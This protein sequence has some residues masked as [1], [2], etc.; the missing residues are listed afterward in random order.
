MSAD[1]PTID[2]LSRR[3]LKAMDQ[4]GNCRD[5]KHAMATH[6]TNR[7]QNQKT[8]ENL[9]SLLQRRQQ[10]VDTNDVEHARSRATVSNQMPDEEAQTQHRQE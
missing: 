6:W 3:L 7:Q 1:L 10:R 8:P 5:G 2:L 4:I 9:K